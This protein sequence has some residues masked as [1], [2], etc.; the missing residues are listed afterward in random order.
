MRGSGRNIFSPNF[1]NWRSFA[2]SATKRPKSMRERGSAETR[3]KFF[4]H[5]TAANH[6]AAFENNRFKAALRQ[7]KRGNQRVVTTAN[8]HYLLSDRHGQFAA[9]FHSF[10]ITW[11]AMRP[12]APIMPPPGCVAEPHMNRLLTGVR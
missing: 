3:M 12:L 8:E 5:R 6:F 1:S 9:F 4:R 7:I 10:R 11:L 2:T